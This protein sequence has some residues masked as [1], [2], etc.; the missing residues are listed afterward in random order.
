[1]NKNCGL[2][3]N[4]LANLEFCF[5]MK[6]IFFSLKEENHVLTLLQDTPSG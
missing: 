1:M 6:T 2:R 5:I 4:C 3:E